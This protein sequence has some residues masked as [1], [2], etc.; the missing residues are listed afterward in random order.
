[1]HLLLNKL[2]SDNL[3]GTVYWVASVQPRIT[4]AENMNP[5]FYFLGRIVNVLFH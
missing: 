4:A 2:G 5:D 3:S 1:M